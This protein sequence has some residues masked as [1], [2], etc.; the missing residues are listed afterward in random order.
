VA[1]VAVVVGG[2]ELVRSVGAWRRGLPGSLAPV[3]VGTEAL[4]VSAG[5][6]PDAR[7]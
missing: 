2:R 3:V 6:L 7:R 5:G 1:V 4:G